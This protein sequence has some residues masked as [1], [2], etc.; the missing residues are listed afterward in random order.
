MYI[1]VWKKRSVA[2]SVSLQLYILQY[3][4]IKMTKSHDKIIKTKKKNNFSQLI[5]LVTAMIFLDVFFFFFFF[6]TW[7]KV[8]FYF[9]IFAWLNSPSL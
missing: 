4:Y 8:S 5:I 6:V 1:A 9:K 7:V 3:I 2:T